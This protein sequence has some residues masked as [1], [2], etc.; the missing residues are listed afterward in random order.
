MRYRACVS[1][2]R[3]LRDHQE[4]IELLH[5]CLSAAA[6]GNAQRRECRAYFCETCTGWHLTSPHLTSLSEARWW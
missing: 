1:G 5:R 4:A 6:G 3:R 2:K